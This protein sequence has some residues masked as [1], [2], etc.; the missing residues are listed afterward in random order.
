MKRVTAFFS[1]GR[2]VFSGD[3]EIDMSTRGRGRIKGTEKPFGDPCD[4][5]EQARE[6]ASKELLKMFEANPE[7]AAICGFM[8]HPAHNA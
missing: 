6:V 7:V 5:P 4:T 2:Q 3:F 1:Y 8:V